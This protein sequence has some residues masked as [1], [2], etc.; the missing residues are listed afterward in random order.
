MLINYTDKELIVKLILICFE[1]LKRT[2]LNNIYLFKSELS[3]Q[4]LI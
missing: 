2:N 4:T 3:S 1:L